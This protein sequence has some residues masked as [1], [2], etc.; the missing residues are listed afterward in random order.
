[1]GVYRTSLV[2]Q[3]GGFREGFE[4]SQDYDL[5]L[6][7]LDYT[8]AEQICHIPHILYHWRIAEGLNTFSTDSLSKAVNAARRTLTE[9][10]TRR[11]ETV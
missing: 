9:Y 10:F 4:G 11:G 5:A 8:T 1:L 7:V 6:R 2:R 3:V